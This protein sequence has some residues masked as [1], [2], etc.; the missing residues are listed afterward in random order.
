MVKKKGKGRPSGYRP[1][2]CDKII[3]YFSIEPYY[4]TKRTI[5]TKNG[6]MTI[7]VDVASDTPSFAGFACEISVCRDTINEWIRVHPDFSVAHKKAKEL[8]E[9]FLIINGNKG[10]IN[11]AFCIFMAKNVL[12]WT[13]RHDFNQNTN[14]NITATVKVE[15][16]KRVVEKVVTLL[17]NRINEREAQP[18]VIHAKI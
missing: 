8:Q 6:P 2:Y 3:E 17:S 1:E 11:T 7:D 18:Q 12:K 13:D 16:T 5:A 9:R 10:L 15:E 14:T 4:T